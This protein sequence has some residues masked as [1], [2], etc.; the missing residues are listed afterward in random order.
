MHCIF[1]SPKFSPPNTHPRNPTPTPLHVRLLTFF[2]TKG[3]ITETSPMIVRK[4]N[5]MCNDDVH[6]LHLR[7]FNDESLVITRRGTD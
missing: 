4:R 3:K 5:S 6:S 1:R 7:H 2:F